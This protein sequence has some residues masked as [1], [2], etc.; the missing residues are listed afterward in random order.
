MIL[1]CDKE[2]NEEY[3]HPSGVRFSVD[4]EIHQLRNSELSEAM[5]LFPHHAF[6][7]HCNLKR[8]RIASGR[9]GKLVTLCA[10]LL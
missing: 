1:E 7:P 4:F 2:R 9:R 3:V 8:Q 6:N 10:V 5:I